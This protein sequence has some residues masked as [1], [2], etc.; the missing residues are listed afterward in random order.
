MNELDHRE[1]RYTLMACVFAFLTAAIALTGL[2]LVVVG[3]IEGR[4]DV[5][6]IGVL[7]V[8]L[9]APFATIAVLSSGRSGAF[10]F[11]LDKNQVK[12]SSRINADIEG[13]SKQA[14]R[15]LNRRH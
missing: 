7:V 14:K 1:R 13:D 10:G 4:I 15:R 3:A 11:E 12:M 2:V 6:W 5:S 8:A 9:A